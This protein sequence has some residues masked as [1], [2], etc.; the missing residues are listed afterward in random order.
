MFAQDCAREYECARVCVSSLVRLCEFQID[1]PACLLVFV[2]RK[3]II[4]ELLKS[5]E[6]DITML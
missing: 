3:E 1:V 6:K 4:K 2:C 5:N